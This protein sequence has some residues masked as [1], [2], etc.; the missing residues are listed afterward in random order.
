LF[1]V[2]KKISANNLGVD[3]VFVSGKIFIGERVDLAIGSKK[4]SS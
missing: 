2:A 1:L 4:S 3:K